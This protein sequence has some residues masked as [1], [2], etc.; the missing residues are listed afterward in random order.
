M[1]RTQFH[2]KKL[3]DLQMC[4]FCKI[5]VELLRYT[6]F[7]HKASNNGSMGYCMEDEVKKV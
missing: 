7:N 6:T 2:F 5:C 1:S 3:L 4:Y